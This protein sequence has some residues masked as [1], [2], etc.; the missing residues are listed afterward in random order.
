MDSEQ[1]MCRI[2]DVDS[3]PELY[4]LV[5]KYQYNKCSVQLHGILEVYNVLY[6]HMRQVPG[7]NDIS[8]VNVPQ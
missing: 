2:P 4:Q 6:L 7:E 1:N 8:K 3:N 5:T